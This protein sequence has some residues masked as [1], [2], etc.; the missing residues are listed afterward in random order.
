MRIKSLRPVLLIALSFLS[1]NTF[2]Q[3]KTK[4]DQLNKK[5]QSAENDTSK[6]WLL[7][8]LSN[9]Y[10][11]NNPDSAYSVAERELNLANAVSIVV[12]EGLRSIE[13]A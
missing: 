7:H 13:K 1:L 10:I 8:E 9:T 11:Y 12:Y 5:L 2:T 4:I 3:S 6:V